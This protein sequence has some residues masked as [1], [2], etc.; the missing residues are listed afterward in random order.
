V[1]AADDLKQGVCS[2]KRDFRWY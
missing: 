1:F 2:Y